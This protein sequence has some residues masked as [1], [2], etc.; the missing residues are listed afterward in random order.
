MKIC[1]L[2]KKEHSGDMP[3]PPAKD[4]QKSGDLLIGRVLDGKYPLEHLISRGGMAGVYS[5]RRLQ[6]GD[7]VAVKILKLDED[8]DPTDLK[9]FR[10]EAASAASIKHRNVVSI[11]D[12]GLLDDIAYI[13]MERLEG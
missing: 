8:L 9:R 3:C 12:F 4:R 1:P 13:V 7:E 10:L 5:A 2:C 11:Y 6:I